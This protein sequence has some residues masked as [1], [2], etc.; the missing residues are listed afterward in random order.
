MKM[1]RII[2]IIQ[3]SDQLKKML[4]FRVF[5]VDELDNDGEGPKLSQ[6]KIDKFDYARAYYEFSDGK[7]D[8]LY[9]REIIEISN[10][11][12]FYVKF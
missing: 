5:D 12:V 2:I 1:V 7:L 9:Y 11:K 6:L 8:L 10:S 3:D 4:K